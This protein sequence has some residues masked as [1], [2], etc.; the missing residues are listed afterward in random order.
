MNSG[1]SN[2]VVGFK[3]TTLFISHVEV[4][5]S[6]EKT[7]FYSCF[8]L[9]GSRRHG[10]F[11][12][13]DI[14]EMMRPRNG[15][16][17]LTSYWVFSLQIGL[18]VGLGLEAWKNVS[19][20]IKV[21]T[22]IVLLQQFLPWVTFMGTFGIFDVLKEPNVLFGRLV[23]PIWISLGATFA[24]KTATLWTIC[25]FTACLIMLFGMIFQYLQLDHPFKDTEAILWISSFA[26]LCL[27][28]GKKGM[29]KSS[30]TS[31]MTSIIS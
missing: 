17:S 31:L 4:T 16:T 8:L 30:R 1:T 3:F 28:Y 12:F 7:S 15:L 5:L 21:I 9:H 11:S 6:K 10:H 22:D 19:F 27:S 26:R 2:G 24:R 29:L 13:E 18:I 23:T 20:L 14:W 25:L